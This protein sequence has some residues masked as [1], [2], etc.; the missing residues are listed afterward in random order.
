M[1]EQDLEY[2]LRNPPNGG[3]VALYQLATLLGWLLLAALATLVG[4]AAWKHTRGAR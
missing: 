1:D 2:L 4:R 3:I